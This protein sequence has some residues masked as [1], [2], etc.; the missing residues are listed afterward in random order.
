MHHFLPASLVACL[1][2]T[3]HFAS[4][5]CEAKAILVQAANEVPEKAVLVVNKKFVDIDLPRR[6]L[7]DGVELEPSNEPGKSAIIV[8]SQRPTGPEI[9]LD[10]PK[11]TIPPTWTSCILLFFHDV[12]NKVFP[13]RIIPVNTSNADFPMGHILMFNVST[14]AVAA[15]LGTE[16]V[17]IL[18]GKSLSV[19]PPRSGSGAYPVAIDCALPGDKQPTALCRSTWQHEAKA[20]QILFIVPQPEQKIPR[21]WGILDREDSRAPNPP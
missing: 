1:F 11:F 19:K 7:S 10:A 18:P 5:K 2:L 15:K 16:T 4:A 12:G 6:N 3:C 8:L 20:R 14:A 13:A 21:I 9:P 17:K